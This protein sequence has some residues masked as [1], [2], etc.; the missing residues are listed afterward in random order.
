MSIWELMDA[1]NFDGKMHA[2]FQTLHGPSSPSPTTWAHSIFSFKEKNLFMFL[3][4]F[5][6]S[7]HR[8]LYVRWNN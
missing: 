3:I 5:L 1:S 8:L 7:T 4:L 2:P 6:F